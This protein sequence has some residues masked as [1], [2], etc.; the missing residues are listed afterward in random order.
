MWLV[1]IGGEHSLTWPLVKALSRYDPLDIVHFDGHL[2]W[3]DSMGGF[4]LNNAD[5]MSRCAECSYVH[6]ITQIGINPRSRWT[7]LAKA[8][9]DNA[10]A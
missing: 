1:A 10:L 5:C 2:D 8:D 7:K 9:Y 6:N 4:K 3:W